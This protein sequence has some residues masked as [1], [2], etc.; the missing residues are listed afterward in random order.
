MN[1]ITERLTAALADRYRIEREL[2]QGGMATV[3]L[4][5]DLKHKRLVAVKVLKPELAAVLGA[6]R[7]VQEITTTAA[8]QH[9][10]I[11]PL[12]DSGTASSPEQGE[13]TSFLYYVMPFIDGETL[14]AKLD[15]E[16]Q[17]G[18]DEAVRIARD[19]AD[20]LHYAHGRGVVHR[21]IKPENILLAGS[22]QRGD[23]SGVGGCRPMVADFGI[24]L[25]VQSAGGE[26][27]TQTGLSLGTPQYMSPEQAMGE[28]VIDARS[29][30]YALGAVTY[31]MLA[32]DPPFTGSSVQAIVAK[33][34]TEKP[35]PLSTLRDTVPTGVAQA[36]ARALSKLPA[37]RFANVAE[38]AA[39]L[40]T[41]HLTTAS[42]P[43][44]GQD[45]A[46]SRSRLTSRVLAIVAMLAIALAAW[47]ISRGAP[48]SST[49]RTTRLEF[50]TAEDIS[51]AFP[52]F[53]TTAGLAISPNGE[54]A[55][56]TAERA[57]GWALAIRS[58]DQMS[59]RILAG[60]EG[61]T[62]PVFSPDGRWIAFSSLDGVLKKI[63][64]DGSALTTICEIGVPGAAGITWLS[65]RE[66]VYAQGALNAVGM[67]RVSADGGAPTLFSR[68]DSAA[69]E[70]FR[71]APVAIGGGRLVAYTSASSGVGD[72][73][74]GVVRVRDGTAKRFPQVRSAMV[75]GLVDRAL[76]YVRVDGGLMAVPF[77]PDR[78]EVGAP[79]QVGDSVAVRTWFAAAGLSSTG[80]LLYQEGGTAGRL[81]RVN[82]QGVESGLV[83]S[84]RQ[85]VH[86]RFSPN[87]RQLAFDVFGS[88]G[89]DIWTV[90]L[91]SGALQR[92]TSDGVTDRAE[93]SLDGTRILYPSS[94]DSKFALW[95]HPLDGASA[96][97]KVHTSA[98]PIREGILTPD[99]KSIVY[100][101]DALAT[102]RDVWIIPLEGDRTPVALLNSVHDEKQP[103]ISPDGRWLAY[104]SGESG[105]EEVYVRPMSAGGARVAA[106]AEAA[107]EP[108]WSTDSRR[109][110]YRSGNRLMEA[111]LATSPSLG[112]S[113]R[114]TL[115]SGH[116]A[117]DIY[118]PNYDVSP[119]GQSFVMVKPA[120]DH[121]RIVMVVNWANELRR[122][123][124]AT[125]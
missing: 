71:L 11:L 12:F 119:D 45:R 1:S 31:E 43:V 4:A 67:Y 87:G 18:V 109:I 96:P 69:Y 83:D 5:E 102:N 95:W 8:L 76:V 55:V 103:R 92:L 59:A 3:Y 22:P 9:P 101:V 104:V 6:E 81:V 89:V 97:T 90:D 36:I 86:P 53:G 14:R 115:F 94:R 111:T 26:R 65:D 78:L 57:G 46:L 98:D 125:P 64:V 73:T 117:S 75:L 88:T 48:S 30:I 124:G 84:V 39:A 7:F 10:N 120:Q 82:E 37:D 21:D 28:R 72:L 105:R 113:A 29:D 23:T 121:R 85:Y 49:G 110:F 74:L 51:F 93:W 41:G 114:R 27:M 19:V 34:L 13:G 79:I 80:S 47:G 66:I 16:T 50:T 56:F 70:R 38:F 63:A 58:M 40:A 68:A 54:Y 33:V 60:T 32:G 112:I 62:W 35:T 15:R 61:A 106:S 24:A 20:A 77:D 100:R 99:G 2:G 44:A 108:L 52:G 25:A 118:H 116:Y 123:M 107:G 17:L 91:G 42:A 122:R